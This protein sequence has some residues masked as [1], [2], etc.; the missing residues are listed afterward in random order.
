LSE[1]EPLISVIV[2]TCNRNELLA[3]CL[4]QLAPGAQHF[5]DY[6][7]IVT[8]DSSEAETLLK[9]KFPWARWVA[10]PHDGPAANRNNGARAARGEWL[11]FTD[12]DCLP[13]RGWL[14]EI[15]RIASEGRVD[16]IEGR[17]E[18]PDKVDSPFR[19]GIENLRGGVFWS[20]NLAVR[21]KTFFDLGGFDEDFKEA[22][23]EDVEF[24]WRFRQRGVPSCFAAEAV[25]LHPV[26]AMTFAALWQK[27]KRLRWTELR[28][29]KTRGAEFGSPAPKVFL[30][31][32]AHSL[33]TLVRTTWHLL[34][35]HDRKEWR[36]R[37]FWQ[38]WRWL[39]FPLLAPYLAI[40][41]LRF[42]RMLE[43]RKSCGS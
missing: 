43:Q 25:V 16:V 14:A 12:D 5:K 8:D 11:A 2:P 28:A 36:R 42:R 35:K 3:L 24:A 40:W 41:H 4:E 18:I 9:R 10:G 13:A 32:I 31:V 1:N 37:W 19:E 22:A 33:V 17:T 29:L 15:A 6:E 30:E 21:K 20:C 39:T 27:T 26:R 23:D 34:S 7:V 38:L